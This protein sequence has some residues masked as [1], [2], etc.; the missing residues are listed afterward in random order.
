MTYRKFEMEDP[1]K[2]LINKEA[3]TCKGCINLVRL[4]GL[5]Y[6]G[7]GKSKPGVL[8]M[9]RCKNGYDPSEGDK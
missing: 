5:E 8:N 7:K 3:I 4:F 1:E 2:V 9:R 6:C